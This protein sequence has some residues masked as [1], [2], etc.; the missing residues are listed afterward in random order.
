MIE[1]LLDSGMDICRLDF[2]DG[3]HKTHECSIDNLKLA[4]KQRP[5]R[6]CSIM[7]ETKGP[8]IVTGQVRDG[9]PVDIM[10]GQTMKIVT[11]I[12]MEAD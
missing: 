4:L 12:A 5:E 8:E 11:D 7:L 6:N 2:K 9:K 3:D 10:S 1:K